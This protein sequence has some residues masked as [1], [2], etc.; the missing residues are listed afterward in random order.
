M[1]PSIYSRNFVEDRASRCAE[2]V[3]DNLAVMSL[4]PRS[5]LAVLEFLADIRSFSTDGNRL[6]NALPSVVSAPFSNEL[7]KSGFGQSLVKAE[8]ATG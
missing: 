1:R 8:T 6:R 4:P 5:Q 2:L 7:C 3:I